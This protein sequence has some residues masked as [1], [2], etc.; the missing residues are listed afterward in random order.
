MPRVSGQIQPPKCICWMKNLLGNCS[1][2]PGKK[3]LMKA[4][5]KMNDFQIEEAIKTMVMWWNLLKET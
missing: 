1:Q 3:K 2:E 5:G 4:N